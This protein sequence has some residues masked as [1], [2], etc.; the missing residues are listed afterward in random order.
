M[1]EPMKLMNE[2][3]RMAA[4]ILIQQL[5][6]AGRV[7]ALPEGDYPMFEII[8]ELD[9]GTCDLCLQMDGMIIERSHP[10]FDDAQKPAHI[11]CRRMIAGVGKDEVGP[12]GDPLEPDYER[13]RSDLIQKH[14][15]FMIDREK[16]RPL[17][18]LAHPE[19]RDFVARPYVDEHGKRRVRIDWRI[20]PYELE[21]A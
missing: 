17:K 16:Y 12:D 8:E 11:N 20:P 21:A 13:P 1:P 14:G 3:L 2:E 9:E 15:H 19:G 5:D 10:D 7:D 4:V 6:N 18:V